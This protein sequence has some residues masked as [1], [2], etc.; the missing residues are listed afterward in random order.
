MSV[1][2]PWPIAQGIDAARQALRGL[3]RS[4]LYR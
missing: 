3:A 1:P 4:D 2:H